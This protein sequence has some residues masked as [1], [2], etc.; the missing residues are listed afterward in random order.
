MV[1]LLVKEKSPLNAQ[2]S[3]GQ[4]PLHHAVA[5]GHG[6]SVF[7]IFQCGVMKGEADWGV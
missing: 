5:E 4:T 2:D 3:A 7:H 1:E 6:I